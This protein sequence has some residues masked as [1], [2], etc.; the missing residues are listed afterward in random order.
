ME[1]QEC[2]Y[3]D[4]GE[5]VKLLMWEN[6]I[7]IRAVV[8]ALAPHLR[9]SESYLKT[10]ITAVRRG[11][12]LGY[13]SPLYDV[14]AKYHE[15]LDRT[16]AVLHFIGVPPDDPALEQVRKDHPRFTYPPPT[17]LQQHNGQ[18]GAEALSLADR[19]AALTLED[20]KAIAVA[21]DAKLQQY[22]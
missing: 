6:Q 21:V 10:L 11:Q 4:L 8:V 3:A 15:K 16:A 20:R 9:I 7:G 5:R 2:R 17:P 22:R 12:V 18:A 1:S 14:H 19:I 13:M